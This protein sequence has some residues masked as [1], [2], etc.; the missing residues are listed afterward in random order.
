M[1]VRVW[2]EGD[3]DGLR[4]RLTATHDIAAAEETTHVAST[5]DEIAEI[6]RAW[7]EEFAAAG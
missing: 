4:A 2:I 1:V 5:V 7:V 3:A 6:V